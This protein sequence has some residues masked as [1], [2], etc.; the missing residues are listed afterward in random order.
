MLDGREMLFC[1][2]A[3]ACEKIVGVYYAICYNK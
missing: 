1:V 3:T 2:I